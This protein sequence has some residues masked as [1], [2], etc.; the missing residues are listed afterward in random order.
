MSPRSSRALSFHRFHQAGVASLG[1][2]SYP[3]HLRYPHLE[4]H[5]DQSLISEGQSFNTDEAY[6]FL[7]VEEEEDEALEDRVQALRIRQPE[8]PARP[9][10]QISPPQSRHQQQVYYPVETQYPQLPV[11]TEDPV[12]PASTP[13]PSTGMHQAQ[14]QSHQPQRS[15][16]DLPV[17]SFSSSL[18]FFSPKN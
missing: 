5:L 18:Y 14:Y 4:H 8:T 10:Q 7:D 1:R 13:S 3:R 17:A 12:T 9:I 2:L 6:L 11:I 15:Q 16:I